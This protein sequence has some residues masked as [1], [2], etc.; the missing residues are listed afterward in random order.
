MNDTS[1]GVERLWIHE[2]RPNHAPPQ[3]AAAVCQGLRR[4][5]AFRPDVT[6]VATGRAC[7][8]LPRH[9][10]RP[11]HRLG[12]RPEPVA[13]PDKTEPRR[14]RGHA[15]C[16]APTP[17]SQAAPRGSVPGRLAGPP[18]PER[19]RLR[20]PD[21]CGAS[22]AGRRPPGVYRREVVGGVWRPDS[23]R[24]GPG[25]NRGTGVPAAVGRGTR[26]FRSRPNDPGVPDRVSIAGRRRRPG[27]GGP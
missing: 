27:R 25:G 26:L 7:G 16:L 21:G 14:G 22:P 2:R 10:P 11:A 9:L 6:V 5:V 20:G 1:T 19:G 3:P 12:T 15:V 18:P 8:F 4:R 17:A 24:R 13:T 23:H